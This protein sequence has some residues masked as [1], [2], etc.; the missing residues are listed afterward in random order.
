MKT[1]LIASITSL[2]AGLLLFGS[3]AWA[4]GVYTSGTVGTDVSW[5]NCSVKKPTGVAFGIVGV[6]NGQGYSTNPC[7]A[8]EAS[9]FN[10]LS[11]Y[12]NTGWYSGSSHVNANSPRVCATSDNNCL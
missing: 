1:K 4:Q 8:K 3:T 7:F 11:L 2:F 6:T 9:Y 10:N 5:P 12:V